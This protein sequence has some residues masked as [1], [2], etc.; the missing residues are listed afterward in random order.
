MDKPP[1]DQGLI[2]FANMLA[3]W[4][5]NIMLMWMLPLVASWCTEMIAL[6]IKTLI[7]IGFGL[8]MVA[9]L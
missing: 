5:W 7:A 2:L 9:L 8:I 6:L 4:P 3:M 1:S